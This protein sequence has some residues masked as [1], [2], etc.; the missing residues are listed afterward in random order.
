MGKKATALYLRPAYVYSFPGVYCVWLLI[1]SDW[2][3]AGTLYD[4]YL[5]PQITAG[6]SSQSLSVFVKNNLLYPPP[7]PPCR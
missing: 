7:P 3:R 4:H 6:E 2:Y 5:N 1:W